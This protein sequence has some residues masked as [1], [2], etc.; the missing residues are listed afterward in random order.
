MSDNKVHQKRMKEVIAFLERE[1]QMQHQFTQL[2]KKEIFN[3]LK[4]RGM[5]A[6]SGL[7]KSVEDILE[8]S[9]PMFVLPNYIR[10]EYDDYY[11]DD[12]ISD[13]ILDD[14]NIEIYFGETE[15]EGFEIS[16]P[17]IDFEDPY[18]DDSEW[19]RR[20]D[21]E[22]GPR[23]RKSSFESSPVYHH[24][25]DG[26]I[27]ESNFFDAQKKEGMEILG[28]YN[29][30]GSNRE[31]E[32]GIYIRRG[33][34]AEIAERYFS[35]MPNRFEAWNLSLRII[36]YHEYF[37]FI[38]QYH[39]DR[40]STDT[41]RDQKY[42]EYLEEWMKNPV[43]A[44]EEA[45]ANAYAI[46]KGKL[47]NDE[48][49][50]VSLWF[51][52]QPPPYDEYLNYGT[53]SEFK[54]GLA[55]IGHKHEQFHF[56]PTIDVNLNIAT[57]FD[58]K[59]KDSVKVFFVNDVHDS[60]SIPKLVSFSRISLHKNVQKMIQKNRLPRDIGM[61]LKNFISKISGNSFDRFSEHGFVRAKDK[62][63]WRFELPRK[64]RALMTQIQ[65]TPGWIIVFVGSHSEYDA[66]CKAKGVRCK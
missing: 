40:L 46:R 5:I 55:L 23:I 14:L 3:S 26:D 19:G 36:L 21:L 1:H 42:F 7:G 44:T 31:E 33:A 2:P 6:L 53:L 56:S 52:D 11:Q 49:R 60:P 58:P 24:N 34:P 10:K 12:F 22:D 32:W 64:H 25:D 13:S 28:W 45:V 30:R 43:L 62:I 37:H 65:D 54:Y 29:P 50:S 8:K 20:R 41:P 15:E 16:E 48:K 63:H 66:Y 51:S 18:G 27:I 17:H 35:H 39:C 57:K 38:S 59:P 47:S 61:A 4:G 9:P